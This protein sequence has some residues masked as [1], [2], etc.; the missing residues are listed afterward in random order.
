MHCWDKNPEDWSHRLFSSA[1]TSKAE[2][3]QNFQPQRYR[4][5]V[6]LHIFQQKKIVSWRRGR[7]TE[8][9]QSCT[10]S[11]QTA[12]FTDKTSLGCRWFPCPVRLQNKFQKFTWLQ[13]E[14][15]ILTMECRHLRVFRKG[16]N[17][18]WFI[19]PPKYEDR[20]DMHLSVTVCLSSN[21]VENTTLSY[22]TFSFLLTI[23]LNDAHLA[24]AIS[25]SSIVNPFLMCQMHIGWATYHKLLWTRSKKI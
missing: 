5:K 14:Y 15:T 4:A 1:W 25:W 24:Q 11:S 10:S 7:W 18:T 3:V 23:T 17:I 13:T 9:Q 22:H 6:D 19:T 16:I 12:A 20:P 8:G 21:I 2:I